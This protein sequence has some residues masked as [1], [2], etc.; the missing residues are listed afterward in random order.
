MK[1]WGNTSYNT[2]QEKWKKKKKSYDHNAESKNGMFNLI[3][4]NLI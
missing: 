1:L 4:L 3:C 2:H